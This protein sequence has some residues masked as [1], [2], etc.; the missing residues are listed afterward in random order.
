LGTSYL[1]RLVARLF[2]GRRGDSPAT[3]LVGK[4]EVVNISIPHPFGRYSLDLGAD[5]SLAW[6]ALVPTTDAGEYEVD[7]SGTWRADGDQ[8]HYTSGESA[9]VLRYSA[10][11]NEL[12]LDGLPATKV[13]P[14]ARCV[15][16]KAPPA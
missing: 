12:I 9:G 13:G 2:A 15:F 11:G 1:S 8:L 6:T 14:G 3:F 5:G 4:W 16:R 7:G 10:G